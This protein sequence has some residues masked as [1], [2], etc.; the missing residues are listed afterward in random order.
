MMMDNINEKRRFLGLSEKEI[1][2]NTAY[3]IYEGD[4]GAD[5]LNECL[6]VPT[7]LDPSHPSPLHACFGGIYDR[8]GALVDSAKVIR[9]SG[10]VAFSDQPRLE[11]P[12]DEHYLAED[13]IYG[14]ILYGHYGHFLLE[15][16]AR[17]WFF[18][19]APHKRI[20]FHKPPMFGLQEYHRSLLGLGGVPEDRVVFVDRPTRVRSLVV[21]KVAFRV[22]AYAH[23]VFKRYFDGIAAKFTG[24]PLSETIYVS[25]SQL[26]TNVSVGEQELEEVLRKARFK[27][28]YPEDMAVPEQVE[29][30]AR[31][32]RFM[33]ITGSGMHNLAF[34]QGNVDAIYLVRTPDFRNYTIMDEVVGA[35]SCYIRGLADHPLQ[36]LSVSGPFLI[37]IEEILNHLKREKLIPRQVGVRINA[38]EM[39]RNY[40]A[41][42]HNT[43]ANQLF[44]VQK[45]PEEA[46]PHI[47]E[48]IVLDPNRGTAFRLLSGILQALGRLDEALEAA[49]TA[50]ALA[51]ERK[52]FETHRA[53]LQTLLENRATEQQANDEANMAANDEVRMLGGMGY[54]DFMERLAVETGARTYLE[55]GTNDGGSVARIPCPSLCIDPSFR[56]DGACINNKEQT[57]FFK[58]RSDEFFRRFDPTAFLGGKIDLAFLDGMHLFEYL[59]R[60]FINVE[61][62]CGR[63]SNIV[64]HDCVPINVEMTERV[65]NAANRKNKALKDAWVGDVWKIVPVL[66]EYR[67]DLTVTILDCPPTGL[68]VCNNLDPES[69]ILADHYLEICKK[70]Q[71]VTLADYGFDRFLQECGLVDSISIGR[72]NLYTSLFLNV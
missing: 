32:T 51:P 19:E 8:D 28:I 46:E 70:M 66:R 54:R 24:A 47:R 64:L 45:K 36:P 41:E 63:H 42:W 65:K 27:V 57:F 23:R 72:E 18:G 31:G 40:R 4:P 44:R 21:P 14:G 12:Q 34:A 58:M 7:R 61:K 1:A 59:L 55:I 69:T 38:D 35:K 68:V 53:A 26:N 22:V 29:I 43:M 49:R 25:R 15:S 20:L 67:P 6:L 60:D 30:F 56:I 39:D 3:S 71:P 16:L 62:V 37:N 33:G 17:S 2:F 13:F 11:Q 52:D 5:I 50:T 48:A 10:I 9:S